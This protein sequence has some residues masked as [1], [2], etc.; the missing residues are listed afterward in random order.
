M[1]ESVKLQIRWT[2]QS[3][4]H[5]SLIKQYLLK[6]FTQKEV[7]NF[8]DLLSSFEEAVVLFPK[9][10]PETKKKFKIRRAVLSKELSVFYRIAKGQIDVLA[11]LDNRCNL[12]AFLFLT[13]ICIVK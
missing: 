12:D 10:Y 7:D 4:F 3:L 2:S 5:A 8:Y 11:V 13:L 9:L 1:P 6:K